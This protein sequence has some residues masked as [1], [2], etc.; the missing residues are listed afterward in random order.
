[1]AGFGQFLPVTTDC[2]MASVFIMA[3]LE[4]GFDEEKKPQK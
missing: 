4:L 2:F 1:M 3:E